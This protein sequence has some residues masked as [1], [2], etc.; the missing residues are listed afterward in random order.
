MESIELAAAV[1][2][3]GFE[4]L[5]LWVLLGKNNMQRLRE[6]SKMKLGG[7]DE[8][9]SEI[10]NLLDAQRNKHLISSVLIVL[11]ICLQTFPA[12]ICK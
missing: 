9:Q 6:L 11:G 7:L 4:I 3:L 8:W 10:D 5:G 2:G 12:Y 1:I